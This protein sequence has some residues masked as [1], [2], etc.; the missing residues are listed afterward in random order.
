MNSYFK[1]PEPFSD[2]LTSVVEI[3]IDWKD[4]L[5]VL[6]GGKM[7]VEVVTLVEHTPGRTQSRSSVSFAGYPRWLNRLHSHKEISE[8]DGS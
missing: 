1:F 3:H 6:F 4:R 8:Q 5:K 2:G 7:K